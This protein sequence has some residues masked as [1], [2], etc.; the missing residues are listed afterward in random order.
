MN[1]ILALSLAAALA[2]PPAASPPGRRAALHVEGAAVFV[3]EGFRPAADGRLDLVVHLHGAPSVVEPAL[4]EA[5][6]SAALVTFNR[7]GLS[8]VYSQPFADPA[9]FAT[10]L[11]ETA[12]ALKTLGVAEHPRLGRVV[13]SSFSAGF[14]G[15]RELLKNPDHFARIDGLVMADSIYAG[16][17]G[18]PAGKR[19]DPMLMDGFRRFAV[20]A[21]AG[22]KTFVLTHSAQIPPG[23]A[24]T[25][26]T[27]DFLIAALHGA[28]KPDAI[29]LGGWSTTRSCQRGR[30]LVLGFSGTAAEDHMAHLRRVALLWRR[31]RTLADGSTPSRF[32]LLD[33]GMNP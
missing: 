14:G 30:F 27:A 29:D 19:V 6:W 28:A 9:L 32:N 5:G 23:Y 7:K 11:Q 4:V 2:A 31:Y 22:R 24:S 12:E 21:A 26:E 17:A 16:Y 13:V 33:P 25:T 20:E 1:L 10:L 8:S 18:D 15:V 3:P